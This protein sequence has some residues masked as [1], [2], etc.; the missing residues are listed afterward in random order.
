MNNQL[1]W[2]RSTSP[3]TIPD[4]TGKDEM[5]DVLWGRWPR[6]SELYIYSYAAETGGKIAQMNNVM[7][8]GPAG[9]SVR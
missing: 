2:S 3:A 6:W 5:F 4:T 9:P 1:T 8:F 7:R